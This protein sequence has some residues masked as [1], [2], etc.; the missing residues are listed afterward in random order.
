MAPTPSLEEFQVGWICALPIEAAAAE[1]MLDE[2]F[3]AIQ[4]QD[5]AD[6]NIYTLGR[7]GNHFVAIAQLGGGLWNH[8]SSNRCDE[9]ASDLFQI[10]TYWANG[11]YRRRNTI[12]QV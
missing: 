11:G 2:E 4:E 5:K 1:E 7:V 3:D 10:S 8:R 9:Y 12:S 6:T